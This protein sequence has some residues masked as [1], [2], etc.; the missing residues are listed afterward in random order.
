MKPVVTQQTSRRYKGRILIGLLICCVGVVSLVGSE[1]KLFG[2]GAFVVGLGV[3]FAG[4][5]GAWWSN[6]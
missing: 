4:R 5:F 1:D 6:G 2:A 3:Y